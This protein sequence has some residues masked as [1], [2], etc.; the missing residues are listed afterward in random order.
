MDEKIY[1]IEQ[2]SGIQIKLGSF[3]MDKQHDIG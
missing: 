2:I 1:K 3:F